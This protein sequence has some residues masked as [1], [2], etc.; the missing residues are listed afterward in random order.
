M[1]QTCI[2][3]QLNPRGSV[4]VMPPPSSDLDTCFSGWPTDRLCESWPARGGAISLIETDFRERL[5]FFLAYV[6]VS[7][8]WPL[9]PLCVFFFFFSFFSSPRAVCLST[10]TLVSTYIH[11]YIDLAISSLLTIICYLLLLL[12]LL[13]STAAAYNLLLL[14]LSTVAA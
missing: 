14:L 12:L 13:L 1:G 3:R 9:L 2:F 8:S 7:G 10:W 5:F 11:T 6:V 4:C